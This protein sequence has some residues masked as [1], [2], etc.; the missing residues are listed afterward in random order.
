MSQEKKD[1][2]VLRE[3]DIYVPREKYICVPREKDIYVPRET[4]LCL[5]MKTSTTVE[6]FLHYGDALTLELNAI[7]LLIL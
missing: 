6:L 2:Y 7:L 1:I 3:K 5:N 4:Q